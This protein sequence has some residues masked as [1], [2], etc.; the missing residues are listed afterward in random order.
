MLLDRSR[1]SFDGSECDKVSV[2]QRHAGQYM[3]ARQQLGTHDSED[4]LKSM[5]TG[6]YIMTTP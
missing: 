5:W 3:L 2:K 4:E 1:I 6:C